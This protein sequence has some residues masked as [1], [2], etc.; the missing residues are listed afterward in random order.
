MDKEPKIENLQA[1]FNAI[2]LIDSNIS[3]S[4]KKYEKFFE[5]SDKPNK[6]VGVESQK[7]LGVKHEN[8]IEIYELVEVAKTLFKELEDRYGIL[9]P[10]EFFI[11]KD[12][13]GNEVVYSIV[14]KIEGKH[15]G[16]VVRTKEAIKKVEVLYLSLIHIS[17]PTRP[18]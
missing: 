16:E 7:E 18:Y 9:A 14:D 17:E 2:D 3:T 6:I 15:L 4:H 8:K 1:S 10:A 12:K 13:T 5:L 11:G